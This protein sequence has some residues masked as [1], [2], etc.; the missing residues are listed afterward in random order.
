MFAK[1]CSYSAIIFHY[2]NFNF[3]FMVIIQ[4]DTVIDFA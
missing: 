3:L 1:V 4:I 2:T